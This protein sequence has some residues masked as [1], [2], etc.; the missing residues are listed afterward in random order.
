VIVLPRSYWDLYVRD[1]YAK[2]WVRK[3]D[4]MRFKSIGS[5]MGLPLV[6]CFTTILDFMLGYALGVK[7]LI[8]YDR[9]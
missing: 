4:L 3:S 2:L 5:N 9:M 8:C 7:V 1:R 6:D